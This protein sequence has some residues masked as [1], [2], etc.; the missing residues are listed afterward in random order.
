ME[1]RLRPRR[2]DADAQPQ[3]AGGEALGPDGRSQ[4]LPPDARTQLVADLIEATG[5]LPPDRVAVVRSRAGRGS[6]SEALLTEGVAPSEGVARVL[7]SR[8]HLPLV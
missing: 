8:Y 5:L 6:F 2:E 4:G 3:E 7:A 1:F